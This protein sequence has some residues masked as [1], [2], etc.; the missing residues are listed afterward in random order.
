MLAAEA[1]AG[2]NVDAVY[3]AKKALL[4]LELHD[5]KS[6]DL[7]AMRTEMINYI[8]QLNDML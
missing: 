2:G 6:G 3:F 4:W 1:M 5:E 8:M 7:N